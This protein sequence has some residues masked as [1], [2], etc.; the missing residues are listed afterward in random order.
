AFVSGVLVS[1]TPCFYPLLPVTIG[2]I[3]ANAASRLKA[4]F[5]SLFYVL[6]ISLTYAVLGIAAGLS[7]QLFGKISTYP[8]FSL[9]AGFL[10][11]TLGLSAIGLFKFRLP[12]FMTSSKVKIEKRS[13]SLLFSFVVGMASG[14]VVAPC[15]APALILILSYIAGRQTLFFG[16]GLMLTFAFGMGTL[17]LLIGT[18]AGVLRSLPKAGSWMEKVNKIFGII[19]IIVGAYFIKR[20][21]SLF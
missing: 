10:Y 8:V 17:L 7:G 12:S 19:L 2:Y 6:G 15:A 18:F 4:F 14:L 1:L 3:G 20:A 5:L 16:A 21:I 13:P 9:I 11:L